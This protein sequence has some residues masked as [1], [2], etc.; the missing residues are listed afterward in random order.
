[1]NDNFNKSIPPFAPLPENRA[2]NE[3]NEPAQAVYSPPQAQYGYV[4]QP[5]QEQPVYYAQP[6]A[7]PPVAAAPP[8][9]PKANLGLGITSFVMGWLSF[10]GCACIGISNLI[11]FI[12]A[13]LFCITGLVLGIICFASDKH[14]KGILNGFALT[15]LILNG[16]GLSI[17]VL[18]VVSAAAQGGAYLK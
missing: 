18:A 3:V 9:P 7:V 16:I 11:L 2:Y 6:V 12:F 5:V 14:Q 10:L 8:A 17:T 1:M 13:L 15:G 4:Q